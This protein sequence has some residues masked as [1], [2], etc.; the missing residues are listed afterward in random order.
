MKIILNRI[1]PFLLTVR[2]ALSF[3]WQSSPS[4]AI[5][6][7]VVRVNEGPRS[8]LRGITELNLEDFSEAEANPVTQTT[9]NVL[10]QSR[11][12]IG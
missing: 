3:V 1:R 7:T 9:E 4:L 2:R 10:V 8:K 6:N 11:N 12:S 5:G